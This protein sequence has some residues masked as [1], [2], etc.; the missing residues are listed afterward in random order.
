[1]GK[2]L[3]HVKE[4]KKS[5]VYEND[6]YKVR[7]KQVNGGYYVKNGAK[8]NPY[9]DSDKEDDELVWIDDAVILEAES[10]KTGKKAQKR[11]YQGAGAIDDFQD[12]IDGRSSSFSDVLKKIDAKN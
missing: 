10:K 5:D 7:V 9:W 8:K 1:M 4:N 6:D 11:C 2:E 3:K 12:A